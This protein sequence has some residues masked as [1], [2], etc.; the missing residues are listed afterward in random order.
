MNLDIIK[1]LQK[2]NDQKQEPWD[3]DPQEDRYVITEKATGR[4]IDD[5]GGYGYK[6]FESARKA[7]W[8]R[9]EGG[10][11]KTNS[12][13]SEATKFWKNN[14]AIK[15]FVNDFY[16]CNVKEI[17]RGEFSDNDLIKGIK[18]KF[19]IDINRKYFEYA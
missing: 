5:A 9:F 2:K 11:K 17:A 16:M 15:V 10:K 18:E 6:S 19:N 14:Q 1:M 3:C 13:R 7:M 4:T 12:M 8:Y